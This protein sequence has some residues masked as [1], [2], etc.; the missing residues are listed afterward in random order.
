[1]PDFFPIAVELFEEKM[2]IA[3]L[4]ASLFD[5]SLGSACSKH[6]CLLSRDWRLLA[7]NEFALLDSKL[8]SIHAYEEI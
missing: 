1:M 6:Q 5:R 3:F 4:Q 7:S 8:H 2:V